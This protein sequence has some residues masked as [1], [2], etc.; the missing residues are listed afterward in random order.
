MPGG[1]PGIQTRGEGTD[2]RAGLARPLPVRPPGGKS[3]LELL[4]KASWELTGEQLD[5]LKEVLMPQ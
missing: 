4:L 5:I 1:R 2:R 3:D